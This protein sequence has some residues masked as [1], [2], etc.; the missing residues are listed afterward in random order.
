MNRSALL[1][2]VAAFAATGPAD[3]CS[4]S[5][6]L[7]NS[8]PSEYEAVDAASR[9]FLGRVA[10]PAGVDEVRL[11]LEAIKGNPA[12]S[13]DISLSVAEGEPGSREGDYHLV[14]LTGDGESG[15]SVSAL[16]QV[17]PDDDRVRTVRHFAEI[18]ALDDDEGEKKAL[19]EL[20]KAAAEDREGRYPKDL[21]KRIDE[22]FANPTPAKSFSDLMDL[23]YH[24]ES[25]DD[26]LAVVW[27]LSHG[28]HPETAA[29]FRGLLFGGE[30]AGLL[31]PLP[32]WFREDR[33]DE[34]PRIGDL[35]R[36]YLG[37]PRGERSPVLNLLVAAA[38]PEDAP[39]L[40][41]LLADSGEYEIE[42]LAAAAL[43]FR[44][45]DEPRPDW[46]ELPPDERLKTDL[47]A[48]WLGP[49]RLNGG[50]EGVGELLQEEAGRWRSAEGPEELARLFE[51][52]ADPAERRQILVEVF[53]RQD[54]DEYDLAIV[55]RL[56]RS[57]KEGE[58]HLLLQ[59]IA[60][61]S[62]SE[63]EV[64]ALYRSA[65]SDEERE[66]ALWIA[67][68]AQSMEQIGELAPLKDVVRAFLSSPSLDARFNLG[69]EIAG[70]LAGPDDLPLMLETLDAGTEL[71][72]EILAP[73][74]EE[75]LSE[76]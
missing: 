26:R 57:A 11:E 65:R 36:I 12:E 62:P 34:L 29:F 13:I 45:E 73:Y 55:W 66:K 71:D 67:G 44:S 50:I 68:A 37:H 15:W 25:D 59:R 3:A 2:V 41:S 51:A 28:D 56:F 39:L 60:Y 64:A 14:V 24:A 33:L 40:W 53:R 47:T 30:S 58:A 5:V 42:P 32:N 6:A 21:V 43:S 72:A 76:P 46:L 17:E 38:E 35:A 18:S 10:G 69:E 75:L 27:A 22:H 16:Y 74:F 8:E 9:I 19:R 4:F 70:N 1:L 52:A 49:D 7:P 63:E 48:L 54:E 31:E 61:I 20:R 23:Y